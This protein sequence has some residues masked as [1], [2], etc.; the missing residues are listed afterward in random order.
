MK[1]FLL[2][3][4]GLAILVVLIGLFSLYVSPHCA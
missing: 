4:L 2:Y 1:E 3:M